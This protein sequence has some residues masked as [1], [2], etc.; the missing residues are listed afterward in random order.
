MTIR[1]L[2]LIVKLRLNQNKLVKC[3]MKKYRS[4]RINNYRNSFYYLFSLEEKIDHYN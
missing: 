1:L 2:A 3:I 4:L